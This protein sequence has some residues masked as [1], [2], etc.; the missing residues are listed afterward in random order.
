MSVTKVKTLFF[1]GADGF[2]K[3]FILPLFIYGRYWGY[4]SKVLPDFFVFDFVI[5]VKRKTS[6]FIPVIQLY[7]SS[8]IK[9]KP[10]LSQFL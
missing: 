4:T 8:N 2:F 3:N 6:F 5:D 9:T 7:L 10:P 1:T